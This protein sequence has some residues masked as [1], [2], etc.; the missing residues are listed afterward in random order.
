MERMIEG[1]V[2]EAVANRWLIIVTA[3]LLRQPEY[4]TAIRL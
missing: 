1:K 2:E 4:Q 3:G